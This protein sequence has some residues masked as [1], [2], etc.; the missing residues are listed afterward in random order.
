VDAFLTEVLLRPPD[1]A[2]RDFNKAAL[3]QGETTPKEGRG[4]FT[5]RRVNSKMPVETLLS[6]EAALMA[7]PR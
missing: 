6:A 1:I 7:T 3:F 5:Y 2:L 4:L